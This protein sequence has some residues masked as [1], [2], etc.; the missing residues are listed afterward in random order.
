MVQAKNIALQTVKKSAVATNAIQNHVNN[1]PPDGQCTDYY[2]VDYN[3]ETGEIY[4]AEYAFTSCLNNGGGGGSAMAQEQVV[5]QQ[6]AQSDISGTYSTS[7]GLDVTAVETLPLTRKRNYRWKFY[8]GLSWN[9][10]SLEV[11]KH[12]Y[13]SS[14]CKWFWVSLAHNSVAINGFWAPGTISCTVNNAIP[15]VYDQYA[16]M[17]LDYTIKFQ[18]VCKGS[19]FTSSKSDDS[20]MIFSVNQ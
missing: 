20:G 16:G 19:G 10:S 13:R 17:E 1:A 8:E 9:A 2:W 3:S 11:G 15:S 7:E 12:E 5:C 4:S 6:S 14:D 18:F